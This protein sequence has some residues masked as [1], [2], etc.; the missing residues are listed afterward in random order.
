DKQQRLQPIG[1]EG[2]LYIAGEGLARGYLNRPELTAERFVDNPF[3]PGERMYR[4]GDLAKWLPDGSIE[5]LGRIDHQVKI[6][7]Y[8]IELG[9]VEAQLLKTASVREAV[10]TVREDEGGRKELCAYFVADRELTVRELR[11]AL[12]QELPDY[13]IPSHFVQLEKMPLT[14][15]G[16]L[17]HKALPAPEGSAAARE[18]YVAPRS[19]AEKT[20]AAVWQ[21]VLGAERIGVKDHFFEL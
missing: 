20:L 16:K 13:M 21:A 10:V 8:R 12:S 3:A 5:Y 2:E 14:P 17:D 7:G 9:E 1:V 18:E 15:N 19:E 11:G 6:R 4:T